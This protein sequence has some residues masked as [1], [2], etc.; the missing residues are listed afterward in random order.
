MVISLWPRFLTDP[1]HTFN[2]GANH[3]RSLVGG[4]ETETETELIVS[5]QPHRQSSASVI[6]DVTSDVI[7]GQF[8]AVAAAAAV[9]QRRVHRRLLVSA[10][11]RRT[12]V[13]IC[14]VNNPT[15]I[16]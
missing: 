10:V 14:P 13:A 12:T 8:D 9:T 3:G 15:I 4:A 16:A 11:H 1:V 7:V 5:T 6:G 2:Y